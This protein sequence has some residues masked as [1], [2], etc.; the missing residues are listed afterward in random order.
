[1]SIALPTMSR[2]LTTGISEKLGTKT[3]IACVA[4]GVFVVVNAIKTTA[5]VYR[6]RKAAEETPGS[7]KYIT[8]QISKVA[9]VAATFF[10]SAVFLSVTLRNHP[11][12]DAVK[13]GTGSTFVITG[14]VGFAS[15]VIHSLV[16][17]L[18]IKT[19]T[20]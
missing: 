9:F 16:D 2:E 11:L 14:A 5:R 15:G 6:L 13:I 1:M 3:G 12:K 18:F 4:L 19:N 10:L 7:K 8:L 20:L 17:H